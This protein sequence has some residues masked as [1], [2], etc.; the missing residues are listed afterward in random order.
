MTLHLYAGIWGKN[1]DLLGEGKQPSV[2]PN[3]YFK[4]VGRERGGSVECDSSVGGG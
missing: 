4:R 1:I 2:S 3:K